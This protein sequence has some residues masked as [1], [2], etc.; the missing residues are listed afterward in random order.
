MSPHHLILTILI[1]ALFFTGC[2]T[3]SK[4]NTLEKDRPLISELPD[5]SNFGLRVVSNYSIGSS[6]LIGTSNQED[7]PRLNDATAM[8]IELEQIPGTIIN[9]DEG[10]YSEGGAFIEIA[11][12]KD[13]EALNLFRTKS[14][15]LSY[16][17]GFGSLNETIAGFECYGMRG[18]TS[19]TGFGE[20]YCFRDKHLVRI[21]LQGYHIELLQESTKLMETKIIPVLV[22]SDST[23]NLKP[24]PKS[25]RTNSDCEYL[26]KL[27]QMPAN[28]GF[29]L[30]NTCVSSCGRDEYWTSCE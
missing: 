26:D 14:S 4:V 6:K 23:Q 21:Y 7:A 12:F 19:A 25:C 16:V 24:G 20:L 18:G 15:G 10:Y 13:L 17:E 28:W 29:C 27:E 8:R 22:T 5:F 11:R 3:N 30:N 9:E 2:S 1:S